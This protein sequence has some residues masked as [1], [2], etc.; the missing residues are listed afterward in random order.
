[1]RRDD[2]R[3]SGG[4][5]PVEPSYVPL[6]RAGELARR[7]A[8][9]LG[10]LGRP[11][12]V[13]P[14]GC[15]VDRLLDQRSVCHVGR[16]AIV[17]SAFPHHGEE[18]PLRGWNGSGTIFL[19][20]CN[21]RCVFCQNFDVSWQVGGAE[22][23]ADGLAELML[24]LQARGCHN[25][26]WVTPE[27][28]VPQLLEALVIAAE[29]GLRI[30]IVYNTSSYDAA[31]TL[32]LLDGV[33]DVYMPDLKMWSSERARRYLRRAD[34]PAV[35]RHA[36]AEMHRQVGPLV[37][38][39]RGLAVRGVLLRHLVM[40]GMLDETEAILRWVADELGPDTYLNL[41]GQYRPDGL[42]RGG[43]YPEIA[44][45]PTRE[46]LVRAVELALELGLRRLDAG[47]LAAAGTPA[48][49]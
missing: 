27:H 28:V 40:P 32:E 44:R 39:E 4:E 19:A 35:A 43:D 10:L 2:L 25:V 11:C 13:C 23:S 9:A 49:R 34:Y 22:V 31:E 14:R 21:L 30:P 17:A 26:N 45:R 29:G 41:M 3:S 7:A 36:I 5:A 48:R 8:R 6:H 20:G 46:E 16:R 42:V 47:S 33:V 1:M 24:E 38:D 18:D 12:R 37:L 15:R